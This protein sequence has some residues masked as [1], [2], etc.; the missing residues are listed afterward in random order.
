MPLRVVGIF[1]RTRCNTSESG[2]LHQSIRR[3]QTFICSLVCL[4]R[5]HCVAYPA[6]CLA[7]ASLVPSGGGLSFACR[8]EKSLR[9]PARFAPKILLCEV[10]MG[11]NATGL[12][13]FSPGSGLELSRPVPNVCRSLEFLSD[14]RRRG[15]VATK[16]KRS[17]TTVQTAPQAG[18]A[19][20]L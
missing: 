2:V 5:C 8:E 13:F 16:I 14:D 7:N 9:C 1:T 19:V 20:P 3:L 18:D 4:G 12:G 10:D 11:A 17:S 6:A 15:R